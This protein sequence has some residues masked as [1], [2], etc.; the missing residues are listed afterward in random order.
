MTDHPVIV[1]DGVC[2]LCHG[3]VA[4]II[5]HDRA[6]VFRFAPAQSEAG[7]ALQARYGVDALGSGTLVLI[8][9]GVVRRRSDAA[10]AIARRLDGAWKALALLRLVPRPL[11]DWAYDRVATNRYRWFGR[12]REC[13]APPAAVRERFLS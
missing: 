1:F 8:E 13:P 10:L 2:N 12:K 3:A 4:F 5:R 7:G 11:R 6:G 9:N